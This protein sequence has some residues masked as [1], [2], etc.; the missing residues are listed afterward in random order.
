MFTEFLLPNGISAF[1]W[2]SSLNFMI[3]YG[4]CALNLPILL[5]KIL[6]QTDLGVCSRAQ[7][8]NERVRKWHE[9]KPRSSTMKFRFPLK[10]QRLP[11]CHTHW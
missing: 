10:S 7:V 11:H 4:V 5:M 9:E 2:N 1:Q 8:I 3:T 6:R